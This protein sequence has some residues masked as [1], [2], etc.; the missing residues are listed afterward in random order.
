MN[1]VCN[2]EFAAG[3]CNASAGRG[4][5]RNTKGFRLWNRTGEYANLHAHVISRMGRCRKTELS[6]GKPSPIRWPACAWIVRQ[7]IFFPNFRDRV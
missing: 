5:S 6:A 3:N 4:P 7:R 1:P 2:H